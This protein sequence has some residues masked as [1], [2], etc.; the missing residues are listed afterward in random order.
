MI[1]SPGLRCVRL[2]AVGEKPHNLALPSEMQWIDVRA[3]CTGS[4]AF[5]DTST[6]SQ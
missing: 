5:F 1:R 2:L 3:A 6:P 4:G